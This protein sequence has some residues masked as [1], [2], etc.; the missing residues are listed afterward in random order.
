MSFL[1]KAA[2]RPI[3]GRIG[4][5][6]SLHL[7]FPAHTRAVRQALEQVLGALP[8]DQI[9]DDLRASI[10]L[11]LAEV[12]NNI[13]EHAYGPEGSGVIELEMIACEGGL[14][15]RTL[16]DGAPL[17]ELP[18]GTRPDLGGPPAKLPEG[19]FG[20]FLIRDL[21]Q[22]LAYRRRALRNELHLGFRLDGR[23]PANPFL[24]NDE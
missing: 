12:L 15:F 10:E 16:D 7:V 20:W 4:N 13:V 5:L 24:A 11:V 3:P 17:P 1:G 8:A 19:G 21:T 23:C 9:K 2:G 18:P 22:G 14:W 6:P